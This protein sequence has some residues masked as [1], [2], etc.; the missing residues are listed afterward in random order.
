MSRENIRLHMANAKHIIN[1]T[2]NNNDTNTTN[3]TTNNSI[4][5]N[6][7]MRVSCVRAIA[8]LKQT[9]PLIRAN[10]N[11]CFCLTERSSG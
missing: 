8:F 10:R 6:K 1:N 9:G 2:K 3:A 11:T 7:K 5:N 4:N